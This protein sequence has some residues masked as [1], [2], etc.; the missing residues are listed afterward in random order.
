M[1]SWNLAFPE[2]KHENVDKAT[3][4]ILSGNGRQKYIHGFVY[5]TYQHIC[6]IHLHWSE[7]IVPH[8]VLLC[9]PYTDVK[10]IT[11]AGR[12]YHHDNLNGKRPLGTHG[13][14][15]I[16]LQDKLIQPGVIQIWT[17]KGE[18]HQM[19]GFGVHFDS[20]VKLISGSW[21]LV[22]RE[23][24]ELDALSLTKPPEM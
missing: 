16:P 11:Q 12:M 21:I 1:D 9:I 19:Y 22:T 7:L 6:F 15:I 24:N 13:S 8:T 10:A 17:N 20:V 3:P 18:C 4:C 2:L 5:V 23:T 14:N